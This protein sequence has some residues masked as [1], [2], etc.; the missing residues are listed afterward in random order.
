MRAHC[1]E[2]KDA[3]GLAEGNRRYVSHM[4]INRELTA[5]MKTK[6]RTLLHRM[7]S[8]KCPDD[9]VQSVYIAIPASD[10]AYMCNLIGASKV[11]N[12]FATSMRRYMKT[13]FELQ[14]ASK[15]DQE[16]RGRMVV[17]DTQSIAISAAAQAT[18]NQGKKPPKEVSDIIDDEDAVDIFDEPAQEFSSKG[19]RKGIRQTGGNNIAEGS[20][21]DRIFAGSLCCE[22]TGDKSGKFLWNEPL[23]Q[24]RLFLMTCMEYNFQSAWTARDTAFIDTLYSPTTDPFNDPQA[25]ELIGVGYLY[26]DSLQYL[27]DINDIIP[28]VSLQGDKCGAIKIKG[29]VWIDKI[30]TAPPYLNIDEEKTLKCFDNKMCVLR[31][32]FENMMD[33]PPNHCSNTY[34][35]FKF[36][37]HNKPYTTVR[38]GGC[39]VHPMIN[40]PVRVDQRITGDFLDFVERGSLELEVYGKRKPKTQRTSAISLIMKANYL[41][42][43]TIP[44]LSTANEDENGDDEDDDH[45]DDIDQEQQQTL[46]EKIQE[47]TTSLQKSQNSINAN[48]KIIETL[49][50]DKSKL[51][52]KL[53]RAEARF[54]DLEDSLPQKYKSKKGKNVAANDGCYIM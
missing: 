38:H 1:G 42:G 50:A 40:C 3:I 17:L 44:D 9:L 24:E 54:Q 46:E 23:V 34:I 8:Y 49:G 41:T 14:N 13:K 18:V 48:K 28:I 43:E 21:V 5:V 31:L 47:L 11:I 33:L 29:R 22:N 53:K 52:E 16:Q 15:S 2:L 35:R 36:F 30:E 6:E 4:A 25:D 39:S 12:F 7:D 37:Y 10:R 26:L 51:E 45:A 19:R 27:V 20:A 32:H